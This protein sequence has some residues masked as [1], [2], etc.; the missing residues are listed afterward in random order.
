VTDH[1]GM[2]EDEIFAIGHAGEM[3]EVALHTSLYFLQED[4]E[5]PGLRLTPEDIRLLE[6][7]VEQRYLR[8]VMRDLN[9]RYRNKSIYRGLARAAANWQRL[10]RFARRGKRD[11][12]AQQQAVADALRN[13]LEIETA[14]AAAGRPPSGVNCTVND[15]AG[16][17]QAVGLPPGDLPEGWQGL[18]PEAGD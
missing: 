5:G 17:A 18:C 12:R 3:P 1:K 9:P 13:I 11:I 8:I 16:F 15:L 14:D 6:D 2:I 7:A 4:P 10:A